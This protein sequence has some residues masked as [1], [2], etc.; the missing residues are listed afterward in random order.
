MKL[1]NRDRINKIR[2]ILEDVMPPVLRDSRLFLLLLRIVF[3]EGT[4]D[5]AAFR[6]KTPYMTPEEY[7]RYYREHPVLLED[8]DINAACIKRLLSDM[9]G[10]RYVDV[11]CGRG[12][13]AG[14]LKD[15][16]GKEVVGVDFVISDDL[17][18]KY[19]AVKFVEAPIES[20]PFADGEFDT[21]VCA[22]T[23]EHIVDFSRA[24][25]ELRR[26]T[27]KRLI[28]IVPR[29]RE[30]KYSFNL[31]VNFFPYAYTLLN[32]LRPLPTKHSCELI[33]GDFY[34]VEDR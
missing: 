23:L 10:E 24:V 9:V 21:V 15:S 34:Y 8:T 20:L 5:Y 28:V 1:L 6:P 22:H 31:H 29:E 18:K 32:R 16:S 30:Y 17:R 25:A 12:Y 13:F 3:K 26:V 14:L 27:G 11:G 19:P 7:A 2:F 33:D 4:A